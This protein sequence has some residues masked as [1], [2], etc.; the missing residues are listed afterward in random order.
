MDLF[1]VVRVFVCVREREK[2]RNVSD[3][4]IIERLGEI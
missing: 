3:R 4:L 2:K 1:L